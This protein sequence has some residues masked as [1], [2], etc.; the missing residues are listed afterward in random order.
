MRNSGG[1]D[2]SSA[3]DATG[4]LHANVAEPIRGS[5]SDS[6]LATLLER[7]LIERNAHQLSVTARSFVD[8]RG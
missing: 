4:S 7:A 8:L 5:A 1:K 6:A 3:P 2:A